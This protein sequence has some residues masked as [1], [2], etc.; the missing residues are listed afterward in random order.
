MGTHPIF[1][2]DF[3]CLTDFREV[4]YHRKNAPQLGTTSSN[5]RFTSPTLSRSILEVFTRSREGFLHLRRQWCS[6]RSLFDRQGRARS[7]W[8][9]WCCRQK[10]PYAI[11][12]IQITSYL[13]VPPTQC[14]FS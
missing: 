14:L 13:L 11:I 3:D 2:S 1:E 6:D 10:G 12:V 4:K 9:W 8:C 5:D 7:R